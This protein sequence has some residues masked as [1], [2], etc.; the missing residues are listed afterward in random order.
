MTSEI[1][2]LLTTAAGAGFVHTILGPDHYLP[3]ILIGKAK[4]W[5]LAK[6]L[7]LT[8]ICGIGH[9]L[10][11]VLLGMVGVVIGTSVDKLKF[12]ES[13]RGDMAAWGLIA[14][15]L[16]YAVWGLRNALKNKPHTHMHIHADGNIHQ[17]YHQHSESHSHIHQTEK[18][19][20]ITPWLLFIIFVLGPCEILIP[21][22]MYPAAQYS[23]WGMIQ[24]TTVFG[25]STLLTMMGTVFFISY[26]F[27]FVSIKKLGLY[28]HFIAGI[29]VFLSGL[30]IQLLGI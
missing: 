24:V 8:F 20:S 13:I 2:I 7:I 17:H 30:A 27:T 3:F 26:G 22:L 29:M 19:R 1:Q 10:G 9:V 15:G 25:V 12:I 5:N 21:L 16:V 6:V 23:V 18:K 14:F 11:S 4:K 28:T